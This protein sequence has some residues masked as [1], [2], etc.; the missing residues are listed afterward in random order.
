M[1]G[2]PATA[3]ALVRS[4]RVITVKSVIATKGSAADRTTPASSAVTTRL[5]PL[6]DWK[7]RKGYPVTLATT[8]PN[9]IFVF[10]EVANITGMSVQPVLC[11]AADIIEAI[12]ECYQEQMSIDEA[13]LDLTDQIETW[14]NAVELA[15]SLKAA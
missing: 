11:R 8:D 10:D 9:A 2:P 1:I 13:Y 5:Q 3:A 7:T 12:N 14:S 4:S 6:I 15:R